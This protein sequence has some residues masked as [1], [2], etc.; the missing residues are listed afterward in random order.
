MRTRIFQDGTFMSI[1]YRII[2]AEIKINCRRTLTRIISAISPMVPGAKYSRRISNRQN[3]FNVAVRFPQGRDYSRYS[4]NL[5]FS[6]PFERSL[7]TEICSREISFFLFSSSSRPD[8]TRY[9]LP[10]EEILSESDE[11][12]RNVRL[13]KTC[14]SHE[15]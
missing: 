4:V 5:A 13:S 1:L 6:G 11:I 12:A 8:W 7:R 9:R 15:K 14:L 3:N 2:D 10:A